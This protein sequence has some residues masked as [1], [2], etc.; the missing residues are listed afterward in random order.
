M[1]Y[2]EHLFLCL[3]AIFVSSLEKCLLRFLAHFLIESFIFSEGE[4]HEL[5]VYFGD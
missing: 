5:L 4:L 2:G 3:L 1:N